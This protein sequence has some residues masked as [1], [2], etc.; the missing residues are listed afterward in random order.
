M[1]RDT[2]RRAVD[3]WGL[4]RLTR[5]D[6]PGLQRDSWRR[7]F[8]HPPSPAVVL[9]LVYFACGSFCDPHV[10]VRSAFCRCVLTGARG[11]SGMGLNWAYWPPG[12]D[13][14]ALSPALLGTASLCPT[15]RSCPGIHHP[16]LGAL[17]VTHNSGVSTHLQKVFALPLQG[18]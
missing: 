9:L 3:L 11:E 17:T 12:S 6:S 16:S 8:S 18:P 2:S 10:V 14:R 1:R 15:Q 13:P 4:L 5:T 7:F